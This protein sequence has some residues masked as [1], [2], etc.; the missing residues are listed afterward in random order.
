MSDVFVVEAGYVL[1]HPPV[2]IPGVNHGPHRAGRTV[3][4]IRR[5]AADLARI[6]PDTVVVISPH[7][8]SFSDFLFL[9]DA[10]L[11]KGDLRQFGAP[12]I[13]LS[14]EQDQELHQEIVRRL[15]K[16]G[17]AGGGLDKEQMRQ[18][19]ITDMLD[20]GV[21]VP[22]YYLAEQI[23]SFKLVAMS[24][25]NLPLTQLYQAG[26]LIRQAAVRLNRRI[27]IIASGD[28]S[29]KVNPESPYGDCPEGEA[30]DNLIVQGLSA[31]DL[32]QLLSIDSQLR[33]RAAECGYRSLVMLC[34]AFSRQAVRTEVQNY[35]APYGIGYCVA[36]IWPDPRCPDPIEDAMQTALS[37]LRAQ[38]V[39]HRE[40]VSSP[41]AV[42]RETLES[43]VLNHQR[44]SAG[45]FA[46][47]AGA[48]FLFHEQAGAFVSIKKFGE[49]RGCIGT[50]AAT[51]ASLIEEIIQN[52]ISAG[53]KDP[54]FEPVMPDELQD[55]T[56]S[57]DILSKPEPVGDASE[58]DPARYGVIVRSGSRSGLLLPDLEGVDTVEEQLAIA[59]R[60]A[61]ISKDE[62]CRLLRFKVTRYT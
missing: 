58:L 37:Q 57:V 40:Q 10:P 52:A 50:T 59:R 21:I 2:I 28:Q 30:F 39:S 45:D 32:V 44:K 13:S 7:A 61:G 17:I 23:K 60:K 47:L 4:A 14:F 27:V 29:H 6:K 55:L 18:F 22:L 5:L 46:G 51:T 33:Q 15:E 26:E 42:A 3:E 16:S 35:E 25:S 53:T 34:G 36:A 62:P 48:D 54:R 56:Y 38:G 19:Q 9:Y 49:L 41:V 12:Q 8:P 24:S 20:H 11:L 1:P 31:G 43:F